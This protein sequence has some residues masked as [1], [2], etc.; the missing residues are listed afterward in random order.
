MAMSLSTW[1]S[2]TYG[3][4]QSRAPLAL[5]Y[6]PLFTDLSLSYS[7]VTARMLTLPCSGEKIQ[8]KS[9]WRIALLQVLENC[10]PSGA[11]QKLETGRLQDSGCSLDLNLISERRETSVSN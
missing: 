7:S 3:P 8:A 2:C 1:P 9:K 11:A 10:S 4:R 6:L 5:P